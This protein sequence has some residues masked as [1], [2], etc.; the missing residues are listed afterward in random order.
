MNAIY[1]KEIRLYRITMIGYVFAAFILAAVGIYFSYINLNLSSPKFEAVFQNIQFVFLVFVPILTMR[2]LAEEQ[3]QKTDQ[4]L[5][6]LPLKL[7]QII[8]GKYLALVTVYGLPML[9]ICTYPLILARY[10]RVNFPAAYLAILGFFLLGCA[11]IAIGVLASSLTENPV[12]A[13]VISFGT[14]LFFYLAGTISRMVPNT[15]KASLTAFILVLL[16]V[17][18]LLYDLTRSWILVLL[19]VGVGT[20]C[21]WMFF[22]LNRPLLEGSFQRFLRL[23]YLNS[24]LDG[25]FVGIL[26]I[27]AILYYVSVIILAL[28]LTGQV[29]A[30]R[31]VTSRRSL[32][33]GGYSA[34]MTLILTAALVLVNLIVARL[35]VQLMQ[36]DFSTSRLY[37]LTDQAREYLSGLDEKVTLYLICE[38]QKED[39]MVLRLLDRFEE[40]SPYLT[41]SRVDP[42]LY[43]GF[44]SQFTDQRVPDNSVIVVGVNRSQVV[45]SDDFYTIGTSPV[46]GRYIETGF[47]GEGLMIGAIDYVVADEIPVIYRLSSNGELV[48]TEAFEEAAERNNLEIKPLNLVASDEIPADAAALLIAAPTSDYSPEQTEK[49]LDYLENGGQALIYS[50]YSDQAMPNFDGILSDY[51]LAH[52]GGIILEG[53]S[54]RYMSYPYCLIPLVDYS[55]FTAPVYD[56]VSLLSPMAQ[57]V[58]TLETYRDSIRMQPMLRSSKSSYEKN[59]VQHMTTAEKEAG[60]TDGPFVIGMY[61][62]EDIDQDHQAD[63]QLVYYSTGYLLDPDYNLNVSGANAVL[64]GST[65]RALG[66]EA[67]GRA[68]IPPKSMQV[69]YLSISVLA[70]NFWAIF[71]SFVLPAAFV[72]IGVVIWFLRRRC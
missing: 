17:G 32:S 68:A 30:K 25:F 63:T 45:S 47:D 57:A 52:S 33:Y 53:D 54:A 34:V 36:P 6:T 11:D 2:V 4:L 55:A 37:T 44:V 65:I 5:L 42:V 18:L 26:D 27:P 21:I 64:F 43:P 51:G 60:D 24:R 72:V 41:V 48:L 38:G 29:L 7:W 67:A 16:L 19:T 13:A 40:S 69:Q 10:G 50:N 28:F 61:V 62:E 20:G 46:T 1:R 31:R 70:A 35:P 9:I 8:L 22:I 3:K 66:G 12:I 23:F 59:D 14:L 15:A 71:C 58:L 39:E 49:I 56:G